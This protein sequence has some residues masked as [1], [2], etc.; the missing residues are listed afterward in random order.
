MSAIKS[1][2]ATP[3]GGAHHRQIVVFKSGGDG[4]E[5]KSQYVKFVQGVFRG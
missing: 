4:E 1:R 3:F 5:R 2:V